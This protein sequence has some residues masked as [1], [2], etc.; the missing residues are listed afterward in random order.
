M[1]TLL[2]KSLS[3]A[4]LSIYFTGCSTPQNVPI[5]KETYKHYDTLYTKS[6]MFVSIGRFGK[7][8]IYSNNYSSGSVLSINSKITLDS[9]NKNELHFDYKGKDITFI[10]NA[11]Y[12]GGE[13]SKVIQNYFSKKPINMDRFSP[14]EKD[15]INHA[16]IKKGMSKDAIIASRGLPTR[17]ATTSVNEDTYNYYRQ[18]YYKTA[19]KVHFKD[20]FVISITKATN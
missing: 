17:N 20:N 2:K 16:T 11:K 4:L 12:S 7:Y 3:L 9:I 6:N 10:N 15:A 1:I 5:K 19:T 14:F 18:K 8:V 13:L